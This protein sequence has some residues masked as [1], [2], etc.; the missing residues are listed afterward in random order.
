MRAADVVNHLGVL[1]PQLTG[2]FT[3]NV[4]ALSVSR[5]GTVVTV[6]CEEDHG[7]EVGKAVAITGAKTRTTGALTRSGTEGTFVADSDIDP[8]S[9]K[10]FPNA[11]FSG[12]AEAEFNGVFPVIAY[13]NR[14]TV[15]FTTTDAGATVATGTP[16]MEDAESSLRQYNGTYRVDEVPTSSSFAFTEPN[17]TLLDPTGMIEVRAK[18]RISATVNPQRMV[19][20]YT[21]QKTADYW[22][23]VTLEDVTASKSRNIRSDAIDNLTPGD[24]FRQQM[25]QPFSLFVFIP[26][27]EELG[28]AAARDQ[29]EDLF[30]PLC[31]SVLAA[32]FDSGLHVGEQGA[33]SFVTHGTFSDNAAVYVH[34][35]NFQQVVDLYEE[36][37]VGPDAAVAFRN[38]NLSMDPEIPGS[39]NTTALTAA[40]DLDE[41][42]L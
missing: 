34:G 7:L 41:V 9:V 24:N 12:S 28:D 31:R 36:D 3:K 25:I 13:D 6:Q 21:E 8:N 38:L 17:T 30:R 10:L 23:F 20:A 1:L 11:T 39:S 29:A 18:P 32:S 4:A 33:S 42:P 22:L 19:E 40:L 35:Y 26:A 37:T 27:Q 15:R 16:A 5:S 2:L 14:R